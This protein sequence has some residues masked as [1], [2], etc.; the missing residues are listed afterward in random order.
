MRDRLLLEPEGEEDNHSP[1][2]EEVGHGPRESDAAMAGGLG[3]NSEDAERIAQKSF[4]K[5]ARI[6]AD[7]ENYKKRAAREQEAFT[8]FSNEKLMA[9]ILPFIDNLERAME[10]GSLKKNDSIRA[11]TMGVQ[12]ALDE[13]LQILEKYGLEPIKAAGEPFDPHLHDA[14]SVVYSSS[15]PPNTVIEELR[16]GYLFKTRLLRPSH[17]VVAMRPDS[18]AERP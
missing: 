3:K 8:R 6:Y 10:Y 2:M 18:G 1:R 14:A 11:F 15:H 7:F 17:V 5:Y 13:L 12:L 16:K 4:D 9:E